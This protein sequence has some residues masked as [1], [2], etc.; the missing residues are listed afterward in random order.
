MEAN[1]SR[2]GWAAPTLRNAVRSASGKSATIVPPRRFMWTV[3]RDR[4]RGTAFRPFDFRRYSTH[5]A[6]W[7][8]IALYRKGRPGAD[9]GGIGAGQQREVRQPGAHHL[10]RLAGRGRGGTHLGSPPSGDARG[11]VSSLV[12]GFSFSRAGPTG[13]SFRFSV[14]F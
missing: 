7:A 13:H 6:G 11:P 3:V 9:E 4:C 14:R 5:S 2:L 1:W 8:V 10:H 12:L